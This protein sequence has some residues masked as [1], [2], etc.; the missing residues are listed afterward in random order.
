MRRRTRAS[1]ERR[2]HHTRGFR[3]HWREVLGIFL[4]VGALNFGGASVG[5]IQMEV[6]ERRAWVSKAQF[7]EGLALVNTLPG[8]SGIQIGIFL[9]YARAGWWG[10]LLAGLGFLMPGFCILLALTLLY[11][12]YGALPRIRHMFYGLSPVV[13]GIF[14]MSVYRLS[15]A[16]VRD[17]AHILLTVASAV[18]IGLTPLGIVPTFLLAGAA[19]VA[20]YGSRAWGLVAVLGIL[21][22]YGAT[23]WGNAW[24]TIPAVTE[25]SLGAP[26]N[27]RSPHLW[28]MGLFFLKVGAFTF[29]GG[30]TILAFIQEQVVHHLH[31][32]TPQQFLDGLALGQLTPGPT[33]ILA[34]FVGYAVGAFWG[35]VVAVMAVYLPS[36][37]LMLAVLPMLERLKR[38]PW[39]QAALQGISP[40]VIGMTAVAVLRMLPAAIPDPLTGVVAVGTV[41]AMGLWHLGPLPLI[42]GGAAMGLLFR[43][44]LW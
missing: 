14:A 11:H 25:T 41:V 37:T 2:E 36:F 8:P 9:G 28:E 23:Q 29:G 5:L 39:M 13:V 17:R 27:A 3:Q 12:H 21:V 31:W 4:K 40:A 7:L 19:G 34:A 43:A 16:A 38:L 35:A 32:L 1:E 18:A 6:Q 26:G 30:L 22:L 10:G 42:T 33:L 15:R 44:R 20:L 24:W